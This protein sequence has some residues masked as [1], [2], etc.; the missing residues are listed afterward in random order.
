MPLYEHIFLAR[1]D[2]TAQQVSGLTKTYQSVLEAQ[3]GK[4]GKT[5]YWGL[6]VLSYKIKKNRKAHYTLMN[7]DAPH[8]AVAE[9]E[10]Q[11]AISP[12]IIR[13]FTIRV[14]EHDNAQSA[15]MKRSDDRRPARRDGRDFHDREGRESDGRERGGFRERGPGD[16]EGGGHR[17]RDGPPP[18]FGKPGDKPQTGGAE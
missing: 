1:Q 9:M 6:R 13:F 2:V 17:G 12:D 14:H 7:I 4:A 16:R 3:G 5:E 18:R 8:A 11:M 15:M 10:R